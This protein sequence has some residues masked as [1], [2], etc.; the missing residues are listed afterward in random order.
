[1]LIME[2]R[3]WRMITP[4][5]IASPLFPSINSLNLNPVL[6][7]ISIALLITAYPA[8]SHTSSNDTMRHLLCISM[9]VFSQNLTPGKVEGEQRS[10]GQNAG[11]E[12]KDKDK[13]NSFLIQDIRKSRRT[14]VP[15]TRT[16]VRPAGS[17]LMEGAISGWLIKQRLGLKQRISV[18]AKKV[19]WC[20]W[21]AKR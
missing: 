19:I 13:V 7:T 5:M 8:Q 18:K 17:H 9:I 14:P 10:Q 11:N 1:M 21:Q 6:Y 16:L 12:K 15:A 2:L 4:I 20:L 3:K